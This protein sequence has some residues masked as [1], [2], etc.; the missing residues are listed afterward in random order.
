MKN[1]RWATGRVERD[2]SQVAVLAHEPRVQVKDDRAL[3]NFPWKVFIKE[4]KLF[5]Y[6][7]ETLLE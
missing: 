7:S 2:P 6:P 5:F 1:I 3:P 4:Y